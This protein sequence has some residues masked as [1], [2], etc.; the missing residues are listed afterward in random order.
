MGYHLRHSRHLEQA[1]ATNKNYLCG[2]GLAILTTYGAGSL[3]GGGHA[4]ASAGESNK[5]DVKL[6]WRHVVALALT[7]RS[8]QY[9][10][11]LSICQHLNARDADR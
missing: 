11:E 3:A 7:N 2:F 9:R 6:F 1:G 10:N 8:Y 5:Q 4:P